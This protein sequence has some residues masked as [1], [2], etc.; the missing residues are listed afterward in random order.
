MPPSESTGT[1][2]PWFQSFATSTAFQGIVRKAVDGKWLAENV[3]LTGAKAEVSGLKAEGNAAALTVFGAQAEYSL[4]KHEYAVI[5]PA[6]VAQT[7]LDDEQDRRL[8]VLTAEAV[9]TKDLVDKV[10]QDLR[11][12]AAALRQTL[13]EGDKQLRTEVPQLRTK[14]ESIRDRLL[15]DD[16][17]L[18][19]R[20]SAL[21]TRVGQVSQVAHNADDRSEAGK[22]KL[23]KLNAEV[24]KG[25]QDVEALKGSARRAVGDIDILID[26]VTALERALRQ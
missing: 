22:T 6:R 17:K 20:I 11:S 5:D 2:P 24:R 1:I 26:R 19:A 10:K 23:K 3:P 13:S 4:V 18:H 16:Q 9:S 21:Q 14:V 7:L 15:A 25:L 12:T 8:R